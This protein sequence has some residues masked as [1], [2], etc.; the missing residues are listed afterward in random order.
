M[1]RSL[2]L[3]L[4]SMLFLLSG[5]LEF[6]AQEI[7]FRYDAKQD[8]I[9]ALVVYRGLFAESGSGSSDKPMEKALTDL[10][11]A[12]KNGQFAFWCNWPLKVDPTVDAGPGRALLPHMEVETGGLFTDPKGVLCGYQFVRIREAKA[13]L[14]M[15][16][17]ML[18][19]GVQAA[20]LA[21][22]GSNGATHKFHADTREALREFLRSGEKMLVLEPGRIELRMP[23]AQSDHRWLK[24]QLEDDFLDNLPREM[25]RR[26]GVE[27]QRARGGDITSTSVSPASVDMRGDTLKDNMRQSATFRFFWDNDFTLERKEDV[28]TVGLGHHDAEELKVTKASDGLYHDALLTKLRE[29]GDKI[30]DGLPDQE[31]ARR[32]A[33]FRGRDCVL[34]E[35]LAE[36]RSAGAA[37]KAEPK[38]K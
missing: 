33:A 9:D 20:T 34:A 11:E 12:M 37:P 22:V 24:L 23:C 21:G 36:T 29:R 17:T 1:P 30:E 35:H 32:F 7:T 27:Q 16:N 10:D 8:R 6:D 5:C 31:L 14:Q 15:L 3:L 4:L 19:V 26:Y 28:T 25:V 13:F 18:E 38:D 2:R